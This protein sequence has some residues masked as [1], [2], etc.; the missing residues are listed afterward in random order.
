MQ[1]SIEG[2]AL[3]KKWEGFRAEAYLCPA[4]VWTIGYGHT[5]GVR[6][7]DKITE[8]KATE[9]LL[10]DVNEAETIV[11]TAVT[12]PITQN[13]FDALVSLVYNIGSSNFATSTILKLIN[14]NC[15]DIKKHEHYFCIWNKGGGRTLQ[16]LLN[17]RRDEFALYRKD[18]WFANLKY[19]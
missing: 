6:P 18:L 19:N 16:G 2:L 7:E 11:N 13:Q 3:I 17:R 5:R 14:G 10:T 4:G 1:I 9:Y 8:V 12:A 15:Y